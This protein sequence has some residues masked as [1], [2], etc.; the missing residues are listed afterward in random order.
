M[1]KHVN[2]LNESQKEAVKT[3]DGPLLI[4]AGAGT[5]K[6]KTITTRL[7]YLISLGIDPAN[8][9]TL[10]FT[11]K[12]A[13][14]MRERALMMINDYTYPPKLF[15]FHKFGLY[16]LKFNIDR[17]GR[18]N[19]FVII[20]TDDKKRIL[21]QFEP[22]TNIKQ[23]ANEISHYKNSLISPATAIEKVADIEGE[24]GKKYKEIALIYEKYENYLHANNL[25]DFD[26]LLALTYKILDNDPEL[27][28]TTSRQY[29]YIMVDEYQDTNEL[30]YN[31]LKK[32]CATHSNLCVVGDDDQSI[33]G[34]RGA[35]VKNIL[36]FAGNFDNTV[37]IKLEDNYRSTSQI[38]GAANELI[39]HNRTR[40]EKSLKSTKGDGKEISLI[41]S[42]NE[43]DEAME[44][45]ERIRKL[46]DS[47]V[48]AKD[49]CV[50]F[51]INALSRSLEEGFTKAKI[52]FKLVDSIRFYE[53]AEIKDVISYLRLITNST[54][55]FSLKRVVNKPKRGIGK[56]TVDKLEAHADSL[57][58]PIF[59]L[60]EESMPE[61][62]ASLTSKKAAQ[63]LKEFVTTINDLKEKITESSYE[64]I[65]AFEQSVGIRKM[66]IESDE[67]ERVLNIDEFYGLLRDFSKQNPDDT[68][69]N[70]LHDIALSS[71]ADSIDG[72]SISMMSIHAAKGLEF[73]HVFII[74]LED[75]YFPLLGDGNDMEEERRL[76]YV[77]FTRAKQDLTLSYVKSRFFRGKRDFMNKSRFLSESGV[78][79][80]S[81]KLDGGQP[82][83]KGDLVKH[84]IFGMGRVVGV[85]KVGKEFKLGINFGGSKRDIL[86]SFVER[87]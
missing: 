35:N 21:K 55:D 69:E 78:I 23:V 12:A 34:W 24:Q 77:A 68:I 7:A 76:G 64:F 54:D 1:E 86:A 87:I 66:Y 80:G 71:E 28:E 32:L 11:N 26:D 49:I 72:E 13:T 43:S 29:Q 14:E 8:T 74:G 42:A 75:G 57:K 41:E 16:F 25:V 22:K 73:D 65:D 84:K 4:L 63:T 46:I 60:L 19:S 59:T 20:D 61:E 6:T 44:I 79:K 53:R 56:T 81:L 45:G 62:L 9:L 33:Y 10:T 58:K 5:G 30:Q 70:F 67:V 15:T 27:C 51:R 36:E 50:L 39:S 85:S 18:K 48:S 3:I 52:P 37:T 31:I 40:H 2:E 47:G 17:L 82:Y 38:L 83:K